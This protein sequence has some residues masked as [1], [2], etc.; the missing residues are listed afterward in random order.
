MNEPVQHLIKKAEEAYQNKQYIEAGRCYE[1]AAQTTPHKA[2][3]AKLF[4]KASG[5]YRVCSMDKKAER[6]LHYA[7]EFASGNLKAD[8]LMECWENIIDTIVHFEYDCSFE[9]RG[10]TDGSHDSYKEDIDRYQRKAEDVLKQALNL[11]GADRDSIIERARC[12]CRKREQEGGW[13]SSR[14]WSIISRAT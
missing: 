11:D 2:Q 13:G 7:I 12:E 5:A 14:C 8:C 6:C 4:K 9:W 1:E 10:E 3:A